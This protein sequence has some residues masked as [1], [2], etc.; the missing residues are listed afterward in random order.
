MIGTFFITLG[1]DFHGWDWAWALGGLAL[2]LASA[3]LLVVREVGTAARAA[4]SE[5]E[6]GRLHVA[7][8]DALQPVAELIAAMPAKTKRQREAEVK[9]VATQAVGALTLL[10]KDVNRLRAVVYQLDPSGM[11]A[12]AYAG[13]GDKPSPFLSGTAR[14]DYALQMVAAGGDWFEPDTAEATN[15]A[16]AGSGSGYHAYISAS[17]RTDADAFGMVTVDAPEA[18]DLVDTD[19]QIVLLVADLLAIAYAEADRP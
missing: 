4:A 13:R 18:G 16:Y 19:R 6:A 14:G 10:L 12:V 15:V 7:M 5:L 2:C 11:S 8:K 3:F 17:I 1:Q 9:N